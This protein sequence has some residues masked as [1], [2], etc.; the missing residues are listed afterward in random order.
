MQEGSCA[1]VMSEGE[2]MFAFHTVRQSPSEE[3][4]LTV[5]EPYSFIL[6]KCIHVLYVFIELIGM[7]SVSVLY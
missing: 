5:A 7:I 6:M 2:W 4:I 3:I 1:G